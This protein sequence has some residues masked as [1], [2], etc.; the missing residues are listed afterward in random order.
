M[1]PSYG[2]QCHDVGNSWS[3]FHGQ[4]R[5]SEG[6]IG[7]DAWQPDLGAAYT[8]LNPW[9]VR[10]SI[11]LVWLTFLS[12]SI[13]GFASSASARLFHIVTVQWSCAS[14]PSIQFTAW[15]KCISEFSSPFSRSCCNIFAPRSADIHD[16]GMVY[17]TGW[18]RSWKSRGASIA[19]TYVGLELWPVVA[20]ESHRRRSQGAANFTDS[21]NHNP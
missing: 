19:S 12:A 3:K 11:N 21:L 18:N 14:F 6:K 4:S 13:G 17:A 20:S 2:A 10:N 15:R 1:H 16:S 9:L 5:P 7:S 8:T